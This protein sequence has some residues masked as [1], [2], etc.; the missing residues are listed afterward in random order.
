MF[1]PFQLFTSRRDGE[2]KKG[3]KKNKTPEGRKKRKSEKERG[4]ERGKKYGKK[5]CQAS[6]FEN[7]NANKK[8]IKFFYFFGE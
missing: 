3:K 8:Y 2:K 4:K 5:K 1:T 6:D 7:V